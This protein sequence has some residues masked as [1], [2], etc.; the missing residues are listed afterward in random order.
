MSD[1]V[2]DFEAQRSRLFAL[3]YRLLGSA[4]EAEDAVQDAFLRWNGADRD[5]VVTPAA[6]L[7]KVVTN[8]CLNRLTAARARRESYVGPWLPEPVLTERAALGPMESAEQRESVSLA[9]LVLLER[10]T[11]AERAVFVLREAFGYSHREIADVLDV[12][13]ANSAQVYRRARA[14]LDGARRRVPVDRE[15]AE[16]IAHRFLAAA[17]TG[18][19]AGLESVLAADVVSWA[20]GGGKVSAARRPVR[21]VEQVARYLTGWMSRQVPGLEVSLR[22]VNGE[23]GFVA[24]VDGRLWGVVVL[25]VVDDLIT[26]VHAVANPDKLHHLAAQLGT[27]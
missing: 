11:P 22:E 6:W 23:V 20:D 27:A 18:D 21:G 17:A 1:L 10:L 8:L 12:T 2:A 5:A 9:L 15:R 3:A 25:E 7:A 14:H 4:A 19:L 13:E 24:V 16:V 26:T